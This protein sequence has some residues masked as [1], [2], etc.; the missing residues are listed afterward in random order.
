MSYTVDRLYRNGRDYIF[1]ILG[2]LVY[3]V[4]FSVFI[5]PH[6]IVIGGMSGFGTLIYYFSG[7]RIPVAAAMY[8]GNLLLL[9]CA[10]R[11]LGKGFV[12]RTIFGATI[13]SLLIGSMETYF[14]SRPPLVS[15]MTMSVLMGSVFLGIGI[16]V[17]YSHHGTAGGTDIVAAVMEKVSSISVGRTMMIVDMT[18]VALS[19]L[20]PFD[21]DLDARLQVRTETIIYGWVAIFVYSY[22]ADRFIGA[23]KRTMQF[24][25][26]SDK[27]EEI[28]YRITH[29]TG[30]G[31]S[32]IETHGYWTG[33][34]RV[35]LLVWCRRFNT[36]EIFQIVHEVDSGAYITSCDVRG[37]WGNGFDTLKMKSRKPKSVQ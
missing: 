19:F 8:G 36:R 33:S 6:H 20:L 23:D 13:L 25:I 34:S 17:Y 14:T 24:F 35:M 29:E 37:V 21:G 4:G 32:T 7:E 28:A 26:L 15:D 16:G 22:I 2:M 30:R 11:Y 27:W 31:V 3:A 9:L 5:L 1:I 10:F 12:L 18:I